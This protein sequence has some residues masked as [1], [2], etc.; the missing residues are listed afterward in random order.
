MRA[1]ARRGLELNRQGFGGDGLTEKTKRE[2]REMAVGRVSADKW[3]R[4]AAWIARHLVDLDAPQNSDTSDSGYP[5]AGL[6]AHLLWGSGPSKARAIRTMNYAKSVV[7]RL[8]KEEE[9]HGAHDQSSH[10]AWAGGKREGKDLLEN[11]TLQKGN[12][13]DKSLSGKASK[14]NSNDFADGKSSP[15]LALQ[16]LA[17]RQKFT[18]KPQV[19]TSQAE[20]DAIQ[21]PKIESGPLKGQNVVKD[22]ELHRGFSTTGDGKVS[23]STAK[24][25]FEDGK[26][27]AGKGLYGNGTYAA[28]DV[29]RAQKYAE[30]QSLENVSSFKLSPDAKIG[31]FGELSMQLAENKAGSRS[32]PESIEFDVGRYALAQGFDGYVVDKTKFFGDVQPSGPDQLVILNRT[33]IILPP[34][35]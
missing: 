23:A 25:E 33:A 24:N 9:R 13:L 26:Y 19:A 1:A 34:K 31:S 4:I 27:Y 11:G 2:A 17:E 15:D 29:K 8:E 32:L 3:V 30:G 10:G 16:D 20:Y 18:G 21:S 35:G 14:F 6:V 28:V 5:G 12:S 7:E 22:K